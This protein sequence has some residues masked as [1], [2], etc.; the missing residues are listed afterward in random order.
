MN[1][2]DQMLSNPV[3]KNEAFQKLDYLYQKQMAAWMSEAPHF[4][5][6]KQKK[7]I[8]QELNTQ[9]IDKSLP[10]FKKM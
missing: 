5:S 7:E 1:V 4:L 8:L 10:S 6:I 2:L 9:D 3:L